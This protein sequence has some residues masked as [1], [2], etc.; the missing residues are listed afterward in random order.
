VD[1]C[2][3][4]RVRAPDWSV[5]RLCFITRGSPVPGAAALLPAP[6]R[7]GGY[8]ADAKLNDYLNSGVRMVWFVYPESR[9][10]MVYRPGEA[11]LRLSE[12]DVIPGFEVLPEFDRRVRDLFPV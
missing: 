8:E 2:A 12:D 1:Q 7:F 10:L 6:G 4:H 11:P 5:R 9:T 3:S